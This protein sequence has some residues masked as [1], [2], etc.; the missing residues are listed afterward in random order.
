MTRAA[1]FSDATASR[2]PALFAEFSQQLSDFVRS[3]AVFSEALTGATI[4]RAGPRRANAIIFE[5]RLRP[6][7]ATA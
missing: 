2:R 5:R 6:S 1:A 3:F 7:L 4:A